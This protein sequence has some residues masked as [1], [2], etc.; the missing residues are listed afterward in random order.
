MTPLQI[1]GFQKMCEFFSHLAGI[2]G[3]SMTFGRQFDIFFDNYVPLSHQELG[4]LTFMQV[5]E[6]CFHLLHWQ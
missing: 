5:P 4:K 3:V 2:F 6:A 1:L